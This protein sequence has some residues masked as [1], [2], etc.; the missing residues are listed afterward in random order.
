MPSINDLWNQMIPGQGSLS[1][2]LYVWLKTQVDNPNFPVVSEAAG[3]T[4]TLWD[5]INNRQQLI[6]GDTGNR[7]ITTSLINGWTTPNDIRIRRVGNLVIADFDGIVATAMTNA[8]FLNIPA[9]FTPSTSASSR[10]LFHTAAIPT[11][12]YRV[13]SSSGTLQVLG[14]TTTVPPLYGSVVWFTTD[15]WPT[16]LPGTAFGS[17]PNS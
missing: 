3:R 15:P 2:R 6:Y 7:I 17:I 14:A 4:I 9:G 10:Q 11:V 1:D 5:K 8:A 12:A 13:F 16:T